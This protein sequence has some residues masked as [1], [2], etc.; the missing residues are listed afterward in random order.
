MATHFSH[1]AKEAE[2]S[3]AAS[4]A[5]VKTALDNFLHC[6]YRSVP[7]ISRP[8]WPLV[9][10]PGHQNGRLRAQ[11]GRSFAPIIFSAIDDGFN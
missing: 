1:F 2:Q 11:V 8:S 10:R 7:G 5:A 3:G 6:V 9:D 4:T